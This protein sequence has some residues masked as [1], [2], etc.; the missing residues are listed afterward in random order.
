MS[1]KKSR[2]IKLTPSAVCLIAALFLLYSPFFNMTAISN[3]MGDTMIQTKIGLDMIAQKG[4]ILTD[5][6]SWHEGLNWYP[7]EEGWY[8]LLGLSYKLFGLFGII[9]VAAVINYAIAA[10][11][12]RKDY[13]DGIHPFIILLNAAVARYLSFPNYLARPTLM[14]LLLITFFLLIVLSDKN[15][16]FKSISFVVASFIFS[17]M[18]GGMVPVF[19]AILIVLIVIE[20]IFRE[21]RN[22]LFYIGAGILGFG[23]S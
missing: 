19:F 17:W 5:I 20:F 23:A 8:F 7:H 12:F 6:Y 15:I 1:D 14:S 16:I 10:A 2:S 11:A 3:Y 21:F 4:L 18:H 9:G 13:K 22:G